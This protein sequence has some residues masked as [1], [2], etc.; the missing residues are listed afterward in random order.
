MSLAD[1]NADIIL[2]HAGNEPITIALVLGSGLSG[3]GEMLEDRVEISYSEL[4]GFPTGGVSGHGK[5]LLIGNLNSKRIAVLTGRAHYYEESKPDAMRV[6]LETMKA[7]GVRTL[8]LT[9][10]AGSLE[11]DMPPGELMMLS[12]H[13]NYNGLNPLIGEPTDDRFVNMVNAYDPKV[14]QRAIAIADELMISLKEG[15]YAWYSGPT[16]ETP[17]E[18]R[19]IKGFGAN[20]VGMSTVPEAILARFLGLKVWACSSITNMGAGLSDENISH[21]HTKEM[22]LKGAKKLE[23]LIERLVGEL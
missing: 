3:I 23:M 4:V 13:I 14:R 1:E 17:A 22:A 12:D 7:I 5:S 21:H 6:P 8:M 15:V 9:N 2:D 16:F 10:S 20:A 19:M 11:D 18:I